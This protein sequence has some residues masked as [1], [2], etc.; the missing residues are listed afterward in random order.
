MPLE[1][2]IPTHAADCNWGAPLVLDIW[3]RQL[4]VFKATRRPIDAP[5]L[6]K[7]CVIRTRSRHIAEHGW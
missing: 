2:T 6:P 5:A 4:S 1:E 7:N 3:C